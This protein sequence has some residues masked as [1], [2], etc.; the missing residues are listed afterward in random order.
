MF[1]NYYI[2]NNKKILCLVI[3]NALLYYIKYLIHHISMECIIGI[4]T[5]D[6]VL[7]AADSRVSRSICTLKHDEDK[8]YKF[9]SK[10]LAAVCGESGDTNNFAEYIQQNMQLYE[11]KNGYDL[12]PS[13]AANFTR[14]NIARA[15]RSRVNF[16]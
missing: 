13:S 1:F 11:I 7:L 10:I 12:T 6:F 14:Y 3:L 15:L 2:F 16:F 8:M 5:N 9:S 4:Q